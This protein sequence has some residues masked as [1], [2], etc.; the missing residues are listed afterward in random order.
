M[1]EKLF[2][3]FLIFLAVYLIG[4]GLIHLFNI[5]LLSV[6]SFWPVSAI[7]YAVLMNSIYAS[8][9]L[10]AATLIL[11]AQANLKKYRELILASAIWAI[12]HGILLLFL[13]STQNFAQD[14]SDYPSL[15]VWLPFYNHYLFFEAILAFIYAIVVFVR[16]KKL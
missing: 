14:F 4:D 8:F 6:S 7:S 1:T 12:F 2:R 9:V 13:N 11:V 10:L 5:R 15:S 3:I 16:H